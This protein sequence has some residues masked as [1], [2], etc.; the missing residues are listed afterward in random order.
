MDAQVACSSLVLNKSRFLYC[1]SHATRYKWSPHTTFLTV[2]WQKYHWHWDGDVDTNT[3]ITKASRAKLTVMS[4]PWR[5][6]VWWRVE[7]RPYK[8]SISVRVIITRGFEV[9]QLAVPC[10]RCSTCNEIPAMG[11]KKCQ[12]HVTLH[13]KFVMLIWMKNNS[14]TKKNTH[15]KPHGES[16]T[17]PRINHT[18][19]PKEKKREPR[20]GNTPICNVIICFISSIHRSLWVPGGR[21]NPLKTHRIL[22][23]CS[24]QW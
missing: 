20:E 1:S 7:M 9:G 18:P 21:N 16:W 6:A 17:M 10:T 3:S 13:A 14:G 5:L 4:A 22:A 24:F 23:V 8:V 15:V 12:C 2:T 11:K 19:T